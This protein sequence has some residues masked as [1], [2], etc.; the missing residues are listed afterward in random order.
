MCTRC[1]GKDRFQIEVPD[2][3]A[4][5]VPS[6]YVLKSKR[7]GTTKTPGVLRYWSP[8][9]ERFLERMTQAE[10]RRDA[11]VKDTLRRL[12]HRFD[13]HRYDLAHILAHRSRCPLRKRHALICSRVPHC[14]PCVPAVLI[15]RLRCGAWVCWTAW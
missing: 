7:K 12:F 2:N 15:G 14:P 11:A 10:E 6:A 4:N 8:E 13:M 1:S 9:V 5:R 3:I